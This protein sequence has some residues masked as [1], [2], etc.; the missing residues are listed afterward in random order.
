VVLVRVVVG[1]FAVGAFG[2]RAVD[3]GAVTEAA[4][5]A[6]PFGARFVAAFAFAGAFGLAAAFGFSGV[7]AFTFGFAGSAACN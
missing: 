4:F 2:G 3:A 7:F 6:V 1:V 5:E